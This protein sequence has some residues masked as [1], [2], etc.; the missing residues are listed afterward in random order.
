M[1]ESCIVSALSPAHLRL[2]RF[3]SCLITSLPEFIQ[4]QHT[5][6]DCWLLF[7]GLDYDKNLAKHMD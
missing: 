6:S 3:G 5:G 1:I 4:L 2:V 7:G